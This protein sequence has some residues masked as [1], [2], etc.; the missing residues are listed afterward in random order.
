MRQLFL[1]IAFLLT[2]NL[3][4]PVLLQRKEKAL[5]KAVY[6]P[7][8]RQV[9]NPGFTGLSIERFL[10][11][12][13]SFCIKAE[14]AA[15]QNK[16]LGF[17]SIGIA[18]VTQMQKVA[19]D[20]YQNNTLSSFI[21]SDYAV[22]DLSNKDISLYGNVI[23]KA[24]RRM[25]ECDKIKFIQGQ[26]RIMVEGPFVLR[27]DGAIIQEGTDFIGDVNLTGEKT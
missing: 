6:S 22:W 1:L 20:F 27:E 24:S 9:E 25:L 7:Q 8:D 21:N 14:R 12:K 17:F 11:G 10:E 15:I 2:L 3:T 23:V 13:K 5:S 18:K 19:F 4:I 26:N 16:R